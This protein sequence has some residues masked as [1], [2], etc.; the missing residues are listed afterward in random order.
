MSVINFN[1]EKAKR[2]GPDN[3]FM[4]IINGEH[5]FLFS[6]SY[7]DGINPATI[8]FWA[9]STEEARSRVLLMRKTLTLDGQIYAR[10]D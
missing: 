7:T 4:Q 2:I 8:T 6:A 10:I 3:E 5:W 1:T 9:T